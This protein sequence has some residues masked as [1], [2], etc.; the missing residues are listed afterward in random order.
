[1]PHIFKLNQLDGFNSIELFYHDFVVHLSKGI[2]TAVVFDLESIGFLAPE[3]LLAL[4]CAS[5][6]WKNVKGTRVEWRANENVKL[7]LERAD[8]LR[9][10]ADDIMVVEMPEDRW[11][12]GASLSLMEI[13]EIAYD[14]EQ[15]SMDVMYVLSVASDLLLGRVSTK[16]IGS[17]TTLLSE[18]TQNIIH[19][20][21]SGYVF[22]QT[23]G[24]HQVHIGVVDTGLGIPSTLSPKYPDFRM[25][26]DY[27]Q[28]AL[29]EGVTSSTENGGLGLFQMKQIV[30]RD[31][32][33][34]TVRS[35]TAMLQLYRGKMYQWDDLADIP[36]TQVYITMWGEHP[37][38]KWK[39]L[40]PG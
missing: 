31:R 19:S 39:Y 10:F 33:A 11:S 21:T 26:S 35:G 24:N 37:H 2:S 25:P 20:Q 17:A 5:K 34:L 29:E 40:L 9:V 22:V 32:G 7:F 15:N 16:Q 1:M 4:L 12:R 14:P 13:R 6:H 27:L 18:V 8:I 30:S 38:E 28:Y 3:A 36:G 23:Y